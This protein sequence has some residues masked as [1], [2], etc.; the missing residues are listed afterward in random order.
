MLPKSNSGKP[1]VPLHVT[2]SVISAK[3]VNIKVKVSNNLAKSI[4]VVQVVNKEA[5]SHSK[6]MLR[7]PH[8]SLTQSS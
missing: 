4:S 7:P 5:G 6:N 1:S 8:S 3:D 2:C